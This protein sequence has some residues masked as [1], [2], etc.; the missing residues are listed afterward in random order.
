[1]PDKEDKF[2]MCKSCYTKTLGGFTLIEYTSEQTECKIKEKYLT[3]NFV[4]IDRDV[5]RDIVIHNKQD[6]PCVSLTQDGHKI[7]TTIRTT[8]I[9]RHAMKQ[10]FTLDVLKEKRAIIHSN[11][12]EKFMSKIKRKVRYE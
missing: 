4:V 5:I 3:G 2:E 12:F 10:V 7:R 1:M 11:L 9:Q 8:F 6:V